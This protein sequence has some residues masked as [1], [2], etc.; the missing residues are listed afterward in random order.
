MTTNERQLL[1]N[2]RKM[3][4]EGKYF[5]TIAAELNAA[6]IPTPRGK[7]WT[8][9]GLWAFC[10]NRRRVIS[11]KLKT[12]KTAKQVTC[13]V[14]RAVLESLLTDPNLNERQKVRMISAYLE[15]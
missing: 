8:A 6:N 9:N 14:P 10:E 13:A 3:R 1:E 15:V 5:K 11:R 2:I 12:P 7:T 4:A